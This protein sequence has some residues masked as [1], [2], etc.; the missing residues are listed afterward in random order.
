[1]LDGE[2]QSA[3]QPSTSQHHQRQVDQHPSL[4]LE[5]QGR[6]GWDAFDARRACSLRNCAVQVEGVQCELSLPI[7]S[8]RQAEHSITFTLRQGRQGQRSGPV[9]V[10][11]PCW[12]VITV[13]SCGMN[14]LRVLIAD[15]GYDGQFWRT[16]WAADYAAEIVTLPSE[17][18]HVWFSA[19]RQ[20]MET[21][22]ASLCG[23]FGLQYPS[24]HTT[25]GLDHA[26][27]C[28]SGGPCPWH[29]DQSCIKPPRFRLCDPDRLIRSLNHMHQAPNSWAAKAAAPSGRRRRAQR[30]ERRPNDEFRPGATLPLSLSLQAPLPN[31]IGPRYK[32]ARRRRLQRLSGDP[33]HYGTFL[34]TSGRQTR[35]QTV[36]RKL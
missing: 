35:P 28:Q 22:F 19:L 5:R 25:R 24:A 36:M 16:H 15:P 26:H 7:P 30:S 21:T 17:V 18:E 4:G 33:D 14:N 32:T 13:Q 6:R 27:R 31:Q 29:P 9:R 2:G 1:M 3:A 12:L 23:N 11:Q 34:N 8:G 20:V 10:D